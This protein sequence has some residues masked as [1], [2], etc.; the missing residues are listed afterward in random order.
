VEAPADVDEETARKLA[1]ESSG[2]RRILN[3]DQPKRVIFVPG[4]Q[5]QEPK[6]NIV[7]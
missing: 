5:G 1:L 6:V 3:G 7:I 2:A 4:R